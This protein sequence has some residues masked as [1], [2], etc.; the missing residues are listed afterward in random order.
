[1]RLRTLA[2]SLLASSALAAAPAAAQG[3]TTLQPGAYHE[4]DAGSCTMN[5]VYEGNGK[6]YMGTAAHCV[7][8]VGQPV[9]DRDGTTFGKVAFIGDAD[10]MEWD[11][12]FIE[13]DAEDVG[14]VSPAV[15]GHPQYPTG[16]T[17]PTETR[18]GD[19]VQ[20]SGYGIGFGTTTPTQ[21]QRRAV[22]S[23]DDSEIHTLTGPVLFGDSGGPFVHV[24]TGKALGIVSRLCIGIC[25]EEGP[26]VQG[27]LAKAA[28]RGFTV[29]MKTV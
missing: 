3:A 14:R 7:S 13:V 25:S 6:T 17:A 18:T 16:V 29:T 10:V 15:K 12:A 4:T 23:Y 20:A 27:L 28:S 2:T 24:R 21:E 26:T 9:Q 22:L 1:M 11:F 19:L 5:F 8:A